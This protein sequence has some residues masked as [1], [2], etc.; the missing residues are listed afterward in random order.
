[1][2]TPASLLQR[3]RQAPDQESW[4]RFVQL[5]LP[6]ICY[7]GRGA[8]LQDA[9]VADL[10]QEVLTVLFRT[11][12][13]FDYDRHKSFRHWLRT[14]TLNK[15]RELRRRRRVPVPA[16]EGTLDDLPADEGGA[17]WE[18]EH[19]RYVAARALELMRTDFETTTWQA[20][21]QTTVDNR[22]GAEVA[23]RLGMTVAAVY[24]ARSRVLRRLREEL[25][26]L[27]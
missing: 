4:S 12:P 26:G 21:W 5:Y 2:K 27:R 11:L 20:C 14:V 16:N 22:S 9:D 10:S 23:R 7:W 17:P 1:M 3:L 24:A 8:G 25:D 13:A 18:A 19:N 15:L 6:L